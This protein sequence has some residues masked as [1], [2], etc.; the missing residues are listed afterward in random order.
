MCVIISSVGLVDD[1]RVEGGMPR[2]LHH[3]R[4]ADKKYV[5]CLGMR[6]HA[7]TSCARLTQL[8]SNTISLMMVVAPMTSPVSPSTRRIATVPIHSANATTGTAIRSA[9][10]IPANHAEAG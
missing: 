6:R 2:F 8:A 4:V 1:G 3:R 10:V 7:D 9:V 5:R